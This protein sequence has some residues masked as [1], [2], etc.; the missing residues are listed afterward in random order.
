MRFQRSTKMDKVFTILS[1]LSAKRVQTIFLME[2]ASTE[3]RPSFCLQE[4]FD[5][6]CEEPQRVNSW[7]SRK[8]CIA[9]SW[10]SKET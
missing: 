5:V 4:I 1:N 9:N 10:R 6:K 8:I 7:F 2:M 3:C